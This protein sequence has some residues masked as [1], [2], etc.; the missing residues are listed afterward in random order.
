MWRRRSHLTEGHAQQQG[1]DQ[2]DWTGGQGPY[3]AVVVVVVPVAVALVGPVTVVAE[4]AFHLGPGV[5]AVGLVAETLVRARLHHGVW[6]W[7]RR[8]RRGRVMPARRSWFESLWSDWRLSANLVWSSEPDE[9][10]P[11]LSLFSLSLT[12]THIWAYRGLW[13]S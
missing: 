1:S 12:H 4:T 8:Q 9:L 2:Q 5:A 11:T 10:P 13:L 3:A 7:E 6:K